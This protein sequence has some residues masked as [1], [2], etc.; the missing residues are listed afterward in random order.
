MKSVNPYL[1]LPGNTEEA[2]TFYRSVFGGEFDGVTR[3]RDLPGNPMGVREHD[4]DRIAHIALP[5]AGG[6]V[7]MGTDVVEGWQPL[8]V[9][10]NVHVH[11]ET[12]SADEADRLFAG[13]SA[14]GEVEMQMESTPWAEK[15]GAC[16]DRYGVLWMVMYTGEPAG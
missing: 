8:V 10:N 9:G 12:E 15:Y 16:A 4:L 7:L 14:G 3:F 6:S 2:F 5:L 11:L 13:L 1:N